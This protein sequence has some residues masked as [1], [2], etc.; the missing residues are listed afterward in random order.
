MF[1][2]YISIGARAWVRNA[3]KFATEKLDM[4]FTLFFREKS[5]AIIQFRFQTITVMQRIAI[6]RISLLDLRKNRT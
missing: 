3:S 2:E 6:F 5:G 4:L 1:V